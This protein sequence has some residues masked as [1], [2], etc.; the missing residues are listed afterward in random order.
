MCLTQY[1]LVLGPGWALAMALVTG[2]DLKA[3]WDVLETKRKK[4]NK[5][6]MSNGRPLFCIEV[7][8]EVEI[9]GANGIFPCQHK[10]MTM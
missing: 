4:K 9:V 7:E 6:F 5:P 3:E 1:D 2:P 8:Y 10:P